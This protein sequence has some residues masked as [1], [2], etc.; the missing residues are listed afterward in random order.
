MFM[1]PR[2]GQN[3]VSFVQTRSPEKQSKLTSYC[4][5]VFKTVL[6]SQ[7]KKKLYVLYGV[8]IEV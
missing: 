4:S 5:T 2:P 1:G 6:E 3:N 7:R 8:C